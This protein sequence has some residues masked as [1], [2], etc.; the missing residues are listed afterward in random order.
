MGGYGSLGPNLRQHL[1]SAGGLFEKLREFGCP[2]MDDTRWDQDESGERFTSP[3][4]IETEAF[5][6]PCTLHMEPPTLPGTCADCVLFRAD[7]EL[8][9]R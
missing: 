7:R 4:G 2:M 9:E 1:R 3:D 6:L 5:W 8:G